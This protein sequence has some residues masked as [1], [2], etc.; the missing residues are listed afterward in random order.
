MKILL[1][2]FLVF[3]LASCTLSSDF[4]EIRDFKNSEWTLAS[5]QTFEFE[6]KDISKIYEFKYLI[7]NAI[8]Y[9]YYNLFLNE[10]LLGPD[11]KTIESSMEEVILFNPKSG[12]PYGSGLGDIF[13]NKVPS[14]KLSNFKFLKP[15]KYKWIISH[16]MRPDPLMGIMSIGVE[17]AV[18]K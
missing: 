11:G 7:R 1:N 17:V 10:S 8:S 12:K 2:L 14:P 5:K 16:N 3:F 6:I 18:K 13:D 9:P 15:G 4:K